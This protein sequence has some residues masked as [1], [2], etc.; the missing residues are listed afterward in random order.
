[1]HTHDV[2]EQNLFH[3]SSRQHFEFEREIGFTVHERSCS[4]K[5]T[6]IQRQLQASSTQQRN[7]NAHKLSMR[8]RTTRDQFPSRVNRTQAFREVLLLDATVQQ[9][10]HLLC[11]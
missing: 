9:L 5:N 6:F 8:N 1:M 7:A 10:R 2:F 3:T 4:K 11:A